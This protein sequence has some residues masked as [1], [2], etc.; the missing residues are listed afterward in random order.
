MDGT[1]TA[2][3]RRTT[4]LLAFAGI[5]VIFVS[6]LFLGLIPQ[7]ISIIGGVLALGA[8]GY[9]SFTAARARQI[10]WLAA[11]G[12]ALVIGAILA[13]ITLTDNTPDSVSVPQMGGLTIAF[14]ASAYATLGAR[15]ALERGIPTYCGAWALFTLVIGGTLVGGAIGTNIGGAAPYIMTVGFHLY[16]IAGVLAAYAWIVGL[17]ASY[18]TRAWGWFSLVVFLPAIGAFMYGLFGPSRQDVILAQE[19]ARQRKAVGLR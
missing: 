16:T 12:L 7:I 17:I 6:G 3:A 8:W 11:L 15:P 5:I 19:N 4:N 2:S 13:Y 1:K 18:R 9:A 10:D 14:L